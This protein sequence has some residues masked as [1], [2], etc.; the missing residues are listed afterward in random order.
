MHPRVF[1]DSFWRNDIVNEIFVA[2]SF[3]KKYDFRWEKIYLPA[4]QGEPIHGLNLKAVRVDIRK[5]GDSIISEIN[6]GIA[7]SQLVLADISI[8]DE[9]NTNGERTGFRNGNVMFEVG[10]AMAVRQPVEVILIR[11]DDAKLLFDLSHIPVATFNPHDIDASI[12]LIRSIISDRLS[13]RQLMKDLRFTRAIE[14]L[15]QFELNL[16]RS[17]AHLETLGWEGPS[18]PPAIATALPRVVEAGILRLAHFKTEKHPDI[19][20]WTTFGR[21]IAKYVASKSDKK[22]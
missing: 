17:N 19:Y 10:L 18:Y 15:G 7:H 16:I 13:E 2:M 21:E 4:I 11:D 5:S 12:S 6:N 9:I 14:S 3:D 22:A 8:T 20:V 1:L